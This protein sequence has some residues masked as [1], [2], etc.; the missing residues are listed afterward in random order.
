MSNFLRRRL[1]W[2]AVLMVWVGMVSA[3]VIYQATDGAMVFRY[4]EREPVLEEEREI[5]LEGEVIETLAMRRETD[6]D[7]DEDFFISFRLERDRSRSQQLDLLR[8]LIASP[9]TEQEILEKS[10]HQIITITQRMEMEMEVESLIRAR[11]YKDALAFIHG[12]SIDLIILN[13]DLLHE[14]DV[15][16]IGDTASR[17]TGFPY[18]EITI[19]E[20]PLNTKSPVYP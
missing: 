7:R 12:K 11:G 10:Q 16:I 20:R 14:D 2:L 17:V 19:L 5:E 6:V 4:S 1:V 9:N 13:P 8:E 18:E 15:A 3:V